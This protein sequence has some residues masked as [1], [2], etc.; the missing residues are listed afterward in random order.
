MRRH[1]RADTANEFF[2][3][4]DEFVTYLVLKMTGILPYISQEGNDRRFHLE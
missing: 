4:I 3:V 2:P 1:A